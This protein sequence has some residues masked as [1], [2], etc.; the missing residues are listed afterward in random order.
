MVAQRPLD[1]H[2][3]FLTCCQTGR[4]KRMQWDTKQKEEYGRQD[5][6]DRSKTL[7]EERTISHS[8]LHYQ[9]DHAYGSQQV[10]VVIQPFL[11]FLE[12][13]LKWNKSL[14]KCAFFKRNVHFQCARGIMS[15]SSSHF[16]RKGMHLSHETCPA[17]RMRRRWGVKHMNYPEVTTFICRLVGD[18]KSVV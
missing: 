8:Y 15:P 9:D 18:R 13:A 12:A 16:Y 17:R 2:I 14:W 3:F 11:H 5:K 1:A 10:L 6:W 4:H 7:E